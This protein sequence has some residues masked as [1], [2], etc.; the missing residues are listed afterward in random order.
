[1]V[2]KLIAADIDV[3]VV[4]VWLLIF[5]FNIEFNDIVFVYE[6]NAFIVNEFADS[7]AVDIG[8]ILSVPMMQYH[9]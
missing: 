2:N 9:Q 6:L 1:M 3:L 4:A 7:N 5:V 8:A